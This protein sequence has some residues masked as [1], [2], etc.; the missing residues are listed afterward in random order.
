MKQIDFV[1]LFDRTQLGEEINKILSDFDV[2]NRNQSNGIYILGDPGCGKTEFVKSVISREQYDIISYDANDIRTKTA[3]AEIIGGSMANINVHEMF[4]KKKRKLVVVMDEMDYMGSGDKGGIKELIKYVRAKKTKKQLQEPFSSCPVI[5]IGSNDNDKKIKELINVCHVVR[6]KCPSDKQIT[7]YIKYRLPYLENQ[8][9]ID[10]L[11]SY[12]NGNLKKLN[13]I[14][15]IYQKNPVIFQDTLKI[16]MKKCNYNLFTKTVV[17][18]LY[19]QYIPISEYSNIIKETDRTTLGLL[20]HENMGDM[21]SSERHTSLYKKILDNLCL[22]DYIDRII[23]QN[24]IWELSELNSLIKTFYNNYLLHNEIDNIDPPTEIIFT[25]VLTKYSTE[26]NN[27]CFLQQ[28]EQ[29]MFCDKT[30]ILRLFIEKTEE[31]LS[32]A[33]FLSNLDVNRMKRFVENGEFHM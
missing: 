19:K 14:F 7:Q 17:K 22:S 13:I 10:T 12:A 20:W 28:L 2:N 8:Y 32:K 33:F 4:F 9:D 31:E 16:M 18:Q 15:D 5:F 29:K 25:K 23:F 30:K 21:I 11:V 3:I 26:Y 27:Y 24:Q 6:L 1:N